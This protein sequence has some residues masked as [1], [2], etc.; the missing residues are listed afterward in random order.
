MTQS[1]E[2]LC[3]SAFNAGL[4]PEPTLTV[5]AWADTFRFLSS[6]AASE[7]GMSRIFPREPQE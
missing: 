7:P 4:A 5:S 6:I 3:A 1:L 2:E